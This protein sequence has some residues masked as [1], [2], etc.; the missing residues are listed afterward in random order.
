MPCRV[1]I[2]GPH[3]HRGEACCQRWADTSK[4][5]P[6]GRPQGRVKMVE[7]SARTSLERAS[8]SVVV[9]ISAAFGCFQVAY[10]QGNPT[11]SQAHMDAATAAAGTDLRGWLE[12]CRPQP[13]VAQ[14]HR[15]GMV[16]QSPNPVAALIGEKT[17]AEPMKVFDNVYFLG[18][19]FV[20]AWAI[21]TSEGIILVD[22]LN[23]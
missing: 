20:S 19:K 1:A 22:A 10:G 5:L 6:V 16:S 9:A 11:A 18:T 3:S 4:L 8:V 2:A 23:N 14:E 21:T 12:L 17:A 15:P 13:P 7:R